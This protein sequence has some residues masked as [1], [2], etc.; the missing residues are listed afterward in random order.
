MQKF[1][2]NFLL[3]YEDC[4]SAIG[5]QGQL[6]CIRGMSATDPH[7]NCGLA[8]ALSSIWCWLTFIDGPGKIPPLVCAA[9]PN[10]PC[11]QC[12]WCL[13]LVPMV[14]SRDRV[15]GRVGRRTD[16]CPHADQHDS[17]VVSKHVL[18]SG[19]PKFTARSGVSIWLDCPFNNK[20]IVYSKHYRMYS[21]E[22]L[23]FMFFMYCTVYNVHTKCSNR[24]YLL[25]FI[26]RKKLA[27]FG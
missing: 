11:Y 9:G 7:L 10:R 17:R 3:I 21:S 23:V 2:K 13:T 25:I 14:G 16:Y 8:S 12:L 4:N 19:L 5:G 1:A 24:V 26:G 20:F 22:V 18:V 27:F 6:G 15:W